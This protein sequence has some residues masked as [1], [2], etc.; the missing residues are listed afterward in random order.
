MTDN[1][2]LPFIPVGCTGDRS[3]WLKKQMKRIIEAVERR[4]AP[5]VF[6]YQQTF[7]GAGTWVVAAEQ[8]KQDLLKDLSSEDGALR[9]L[10]SQVTESNHHLKPGSVIISDLV[11][12]PIS[13]YGLTFIVTDNGDAM[14]LAASEQMTDDD[15]AW[16]GSTINYTHQ[17]KLKEK[18]LPLM[19]RTAKW[20]AV[21]GYYGPAGIDVLETETPGQ[22]DSHTGE[23]TPYHIVDLNVRTSGSYA[24][25]LLRDHFTSRGL[26]CASSFTIMAK[27]GR[28]DFIQKWKDE[29]ESGQMIILS[30]YEDPEAK[31]SIADVVVGD[32]D[33]KAL[34]RKMRRVK[35]ATKEVTF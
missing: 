24:L 14:F 8:Q 17:D 33:E 11:K 5:F 26:N 12:N 28:K 25:P 10:L 16:I 34:Q 31:E 22:T 2:E 30:W 21:H 4:P 1:G 19:T 9:K 27:G 29:F 32:K 13:D 15:N 35:D 18:F 7:G 20:V 3:V 6:K 23:R